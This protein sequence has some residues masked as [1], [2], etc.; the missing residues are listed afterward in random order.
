MDLPDAGE[1]FRERVRQ[2][3]RVG[4]IE[5]LPPHVCQA[6]SQA[7]H[8]GYEVSRIAAR[9]HR[10]GEQ[11]LPARTPSFLCIPIETLLQSFP[12]CNAIA[13]TANLSTLMRTDGDVG[14]TL[15]VEVE[16]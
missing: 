14:G 8:R 1:L 6:K 9:R 7:V 2:Q 16:D 12:R 13:Q 10:G 3:I 11:F 4:V 15:G 5:D